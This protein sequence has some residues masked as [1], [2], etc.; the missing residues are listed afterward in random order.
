MKGR[1]KP[2][3]LHSATPNKSLPKRPRV[4]PFKMSEIGTEKDRRNVYLRMKPK[5][6]KSNTFVALDDTTLTPI[7]NEAQ[8]S[9]KGVFQQYKFTKI[10]GAECQQE[11]IF[12]ETC[13]TPLTNFLHGANCLLFAYGATNAG[14]TFTIQGNSEKPGI[15]PR[16]LN[17]LFNSIKD[18]VS[19]DVKFKPEKL[20]N[21]VWLRPEE[22][23]KD[24]EIKESILNFNLEKNKTSRSASAMSTHSEPSQ[25]GVSTIID[26]SGVFQSFQAMKMNLKDEAIELGEDASSVFSVWVSYAEIYNENIYDL[27]QP[28]SIRPNKPL[29]MGENDK[30]EVFIKGLTEVCVH[31]ADEAYKV[32][33]FGQHNLHQ[34]S[35]SVNHL[36]S[37]SH[38][39]FSIKL[40]K[41]LNVELPQ[42]TTLSSCTFVDLAGAERAKKTKNAGERMKESQSI[43]TSLHV[44]GKCLEILRH[45]QKNRDTRLLPCRESKLTRLFQRALEGKEVLTMIVNINQDE[46]LFDETLNVLKFSAIAMELQFDRVHDSTKLLD[47]IEELKKNVQEEKNKN[48]T[49]EIQIR[50]EAY[51]HFRKI[52]QDME[53][54]YKQRLKNE[55]EVFAECEELNANLYQMYLKNA[56]KRSR[57]EDSEDEDD[58]DADDGDDDIVAEEDDKEK[59]KFL[60]NKVEA[61]MGLVE[62][63]EKMKIDHIALQ[64]KH[65]KLQFELATVK[66]ELE[67]AL[68]INK[69]TAQD[70]GEDAM[71]DGIKVLKEQLFKY[72]NLVKERNSDI[73][74]LNKLLEDARVEYTAHFEQHEDFAARN[75]ELEKMVADRDIMIEDLE[76]KLD[77]SSKKLAQQQERS[78]NKELEEAENNK[79]LKFLCEIPRV[80]SRAKRLVELSLGKR[81]MEE[82]NKSERST[83]KF[84][85]FSV[86]NSEIY[87]YFSHLFLFYFYSLTFLTIISFILA[88]GLMLSSSFILIRSVTELLFHKCLIKN[89]AHFWSYFIKEVARDEY[90]FKIIQLESEMKKLQKENETLKSLPKSPNSSEVKA[91]ELLVASHEDQL[92]KYIEKFKNQEEANKFLEDELCHLKAS[93]ICSNQEAMEKEISIL[94][95]EVKETAKGRKEL[96][97]KVEIISKELEESKRSLQLAE[98][99][100]SEEQN[101]TK[102]MRRICETEKKE[103]LSKL[104]QV[105]EETTRLVVCC[106][107]LEKENTGLKLLNMELEEAVKVKEEQMEDFKTRRNA[108]FETYENLLKNERELRE[109]EQ[110]EVHQLHNVML[111][112]TPKKNEQLIAKLEKEKKSDFMYELQCTKVIEG[113]SSNKACKSRRQ[114]KEQ[115]ENALD[116]DIQPVSFPERAIKPDPDIRQLRPR[117]KILYSNE[118]EQKVDVG[119]MKSRSKRL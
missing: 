115:K 96:M 105:Q 100:L 104:E 106:D 22:I 93:S 76:A 18:K 35:T 27:L 31:S 50:R 80:S 68:K 29:L 9:R 19:K 3:Y 98:M 53:N 34:A 79:K 70:G 118:D 2:S 86:D 33:L 17:L 44:L 113:V 42:F 83:N 52:M 90:K 40:V 85:K 117:K 47:Y 107:K 16:S 36:S 87:N 1:E 72:Q 60:Q 38:S 48:M 69:A 65:S 6:G 92:K 23:E 77:I 46:E 67:T 62:N 81:S 91:L 57:I 101:N 110:R 82:I 111:A 45:N 97:D 84:A 51:T 10:F 75:E 39:I 11:E 59:I 56:G 5:S 99:A 63:A 12:N 55:R 25:L 94:Q 61:L 28:T 49:L 4:H 116:D 20:N 73:E 58:D 8:K 78:N 21:V 108:Q 54:S 41:H 7:L 109:R 24:R 102:A 112:L 15:I 37:R 43:N 95:A 114:K 30:R 13:N 88:K 74:K 89:A 64:T 71:E 26:S 103:L 66:Q 119:L 32:F 14:K